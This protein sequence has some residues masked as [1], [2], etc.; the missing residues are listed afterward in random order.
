VQKRLT[1][2]TCKQALPRTL[3]F[4]LQG[5]DVLQYFATNGLDAV[6]KLVHCVPTAPTAVNSTAKPVAAAQ[7]LGDGHGPYDICVVSRNRLP[8]S[9][10]TVSATGVV[11]V[12]APD[13]LSFGHSMSSTA[14]E[15]NMVEPQ[16]LNVVEC[17]LM[18]ISRSSLLLVKTSQA[19]AQDPPISDS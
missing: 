16:V 13:M 5:Q 8:A 7:G 14:L 11:E 2:E 15:L 12:R 3:N 9:Y 17:A 6:P 19:P 4:P 10:L 18:P 1:A